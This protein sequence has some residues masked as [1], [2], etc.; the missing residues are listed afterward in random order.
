MNTSKSK[1][2]KVEAQEQ[3][4]GIPFDSLK[5]GS[6]KRM[7]KIKKDGKKLGKMELRRLAKVETGE[8]FMFRD[9]ELKMT[10]LMKKRVNLAKTMMKF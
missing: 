4:G 5:E 3:D 2:S 6:L 1:Q 8:K 10:P 9:N 7:L